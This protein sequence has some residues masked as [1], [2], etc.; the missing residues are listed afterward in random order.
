M[1]QIVF[2]KFGGCSLWYP[3]LREEMLES[4]NAADACAENESGKET[5]K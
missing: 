1:K 3:K 5:T 2:G 4:I